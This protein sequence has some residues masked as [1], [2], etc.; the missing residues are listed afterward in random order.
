MYI[1]KQFYCEEVKSSL[2]SGGVTMQYGL[3]RQ[4]KYFDLS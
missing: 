2:S 4:L 3:Y 1:Q